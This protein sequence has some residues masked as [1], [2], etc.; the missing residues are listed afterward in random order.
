[1][2]IK[3]LINLLNKLPQ[4]M[5][6]EWWDAEWDIWYTI[7]NLKLKYIEWWDAE[8]DIWYTIKNLK[9]KYVIVNKSDSMISHSYFDEKDEEYENEIK[10]LKLHHADYSEENVRV[11]D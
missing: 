5:E 10:E 1:M 7:K 4:D 8:W 9:L 2:K 11:I 3:T 6:I